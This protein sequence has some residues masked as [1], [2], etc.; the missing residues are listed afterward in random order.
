[1]RL[2]WIQWMERERS[3][4]R[5]TF[6]RIL[7]WLWGWF[8]KG[9][10]SGSHLFSLSLFC[11]DWIFLCFRWA[12]YSKGG[13]KEGVSL[14]VDD[15]IN[16]WQKYSYGC[17]ELSF[18][19]LRCLLLSNFDFLLR[20]LILQTL[21]ITG[22]YSI[23]SSNGSVKARSRNRSIRS[24]GPRRRCTI[25][26][27]WCPVSPYFLK[28][29]VLYG[30]RIRFALV[31]IPSASR[32]VGLY[33]YPIYLSIKTT[34]MFSYYGLA[35][36]ITISLINYILL[37]FQFPVDGY[38]MHSFEIFLATTVVFW[39]SGTVGYTLLEY[40]LG[41]KKLFGAL[42]ENLLWIPFL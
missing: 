17:N 41:Y 30:L 7:I 14:S 5:I 24:F 18:P 9:I 37:G 1:M 27:R 19:P 38:F 21:S 16:R 20:L 31:M 11:D 42:L 29:I 23:P 2:L 10:S 36:S 12:T 4:V 13:F 22:S 39:G 32:G 3:G 15:E 34:D 25:R 26:F 28:I 35:G 33:L 6:Q 40:R 8:W